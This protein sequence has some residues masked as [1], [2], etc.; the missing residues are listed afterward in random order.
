[1]TSAGLR[2][3]PMEVVNDTTSDSKLKYIIMFGAPL[4]AGVALYWYMSRK[5]ETKAKALSVPKKDVRAQAQKKI[6]EQINSQVSFTT[7]ERLI[8]VRETSVGNV[9]AFGRNE[10]WSIDF[11]IH[12]AVVFENR[13]GYRFAWFCEFF[14]L[15]SVGSSVRVFARWALE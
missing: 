10:T 1:M 12:H 14:V 4:V 5:T 13:R 6:D 8:V 3:V 15:V 11:D 2:A 9:I 7:S